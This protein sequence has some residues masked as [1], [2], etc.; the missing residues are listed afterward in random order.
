ML[1]DLQSDLYAD[2]PPP[3]SSP[4]SDMIQSQSQFPSGRTPIGD[5]FN[6]TTSQPQPPQPLPSPPT[7]PM[8]LP[9]LPSPLPDD[10][11]DTI[12]ERENPTVNL[13]GLILDRDSLFVTLT[14]IATWILI[15]SYTGLLQK[16]PSNWIFLVIFSSF[17]IYTI[18]NL[19]SSTPTSGNALYELNILL[20][21]E[22]MVAILF[23]TVIVFV[24]FSDRLNIHV[25]A[26]RVIERIGY[27][28]LIL[29]SISS[30]WVNVITSGRAFRVVRKGKQAIYNIA[31]VLFIAI[32]FLC[33]SASTQFDE[34]VGNLTHH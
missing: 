3:L 23:G 16:I 5:I 30:L 34:V 26:K 6:D 21:V 11:D 32:G 1:S 31:Y 28:T 12:H 22:Q 33:F 25:E 9:P 24:L 14:A 8:P 19:L 18:L 17:I 27:A 10:T 13:F 29:L 4:P 2:L 20:T 7:Q 15:W